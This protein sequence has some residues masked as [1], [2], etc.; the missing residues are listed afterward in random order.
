MRGMEEAP[1]LR[2]MVMAPM[3]MPAVMP[4]MVFLALDHLELRL[5]MGF[6]DGGPGFRERGRE[7]EGCEH[8]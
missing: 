4:L 2:P 6:V 1:L 7:G 8:Q 5:L 3:M